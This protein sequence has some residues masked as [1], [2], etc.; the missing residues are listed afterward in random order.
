MLPSEINTDNPSSTEQGHPNSGHLM[1][2]KCITFYLFVFF[3]GSE[4]EK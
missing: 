2:V 1:S 3:K 4:K